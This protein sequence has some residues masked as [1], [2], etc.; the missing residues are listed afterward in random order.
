MIPAPSVDYLRFLARWERDEQELK[1]ALSDSAGRSISFRGTPPPRES[2]ALFNMF[3]RDPLD[4]VTELEDGTLIL[5]YHPWDAYRNIVEEGYLGPTKAPLH[6]KIPL[7][8]HWV[9]G[10]MRMAIYPLIAPKSDLDPESCPPY[11]SWPIEDRL[12]RFR[13]ELFEGL[14]RTASA[15]ST[16]EG[17]WPEG[18][19]YAFLMTHDI[20]TRAGM[21]K[22]GQVL[23]EMVE[24]GLKPCFFLVAHGYDWDP[25]FC[26]AVRNAG[27]EIALHGDAHDN[28]L[29]FLSGARIGERL[30]STREIIEQHQIRGFRSPSLLVSDH[31]YEQLGQ[32]F[33]WDSSVPDCDTHTLLGPRRGCGTIFPFRRKG[34]LVVPITM[35]ADDRLLLL[36]YRGMEL[37]SVL[38]RKWSYV[39]KTG[40]LCHFLTHPEPHLFGHNVLRD[41]YRA[42]IQEALDLDDC[43]IATPSMIAD[44]WNSLEEP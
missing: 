4:A 11:P 38:R 10:N 32:R 24:L 44:Y 8:Y 39:R 2:A 40:G 42:L 1:N 7:P 28:R 15:S 18:K 17:P 6:A 35:P 34:T 30:D 43:W 27:G 12:D 20:D 37:L 25:G 13:A 36:G 3:E 16:A 31:L 29:S 14:S 23:D 26:E 21:R 41:L 22:A 19:R 33:D 5:P 9:P